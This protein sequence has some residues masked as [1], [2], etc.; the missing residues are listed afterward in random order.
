MKLTVTQKQIIEV[1]KKAGLVKRFYWTGGT[2]LASY[3]LHHRRSFDLDLFTDTPFSH[4]LLLPF[5]AEVK[6]RFALVTLPEKKIYDR[7]EF[8]I[9]TPE[10]NVR[11]E[12]VLY[13][14]DK[15]RLAPLTTHDGILI[16]S[17][18]DIAANKTMA[19][20]DRNEPKDLFDLY[21]LL[22]R[23]KFTVRQL[24][25]LVEQKFGPT[26][27]EFMFWGE[28][29]KSLKNLHDALTPYFLETDKTKQQT[30]LKEIEYFFLDGGKNYLNQQI[31]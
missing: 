23:K 17:L 27:S 4:D 16:D 24:L 18:P 15:K 22:T 28:S 31:K 13:N 14:G 30:L 10:E 12:F 19:Y 2:L 25:Q 20:F 26:F 11:C 29:A 3:Y 8:L 5:I 6:H 21:I 7:W 9:S 1:F